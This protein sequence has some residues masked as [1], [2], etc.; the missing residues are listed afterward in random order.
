M[1]RTTTTTTRS[2]SSR[3]EP[4]IFLYKNTQFTDFGT[5]SPVHVVPTVLEDRSCS[6]EHL[7]ILQ[8]LSH[9]K[10]NPTKLKAI[11]K[12]KHDSTAG[13]LAGS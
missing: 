5:R 1:L 10:M 3:T 8:Q 12:I 9:G 13:S 6:C 11:L 4:N 2:F 7:Q